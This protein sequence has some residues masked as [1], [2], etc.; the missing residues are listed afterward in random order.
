MFKN[1]MNILFC[2][3]FHFF[4]FAHSHIFGGRISTLFLCFVDSLRRLGC[5]LCIWTL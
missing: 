5:F 1:S 4:C 2:K 3:R